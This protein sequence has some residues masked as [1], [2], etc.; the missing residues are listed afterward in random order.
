MVKIIKV[1]SLIFLFVFA[2]DLGSW[3]T[4]RGQSFVSLEVAHRIVDS[5]RAKQAAFAGFDKANWS[6]VQRSSFAAMCDVPQRP[7]DVAPLVT[8]N[9]FPVFSFLLSVALYLASIIYAGLKGGR[10]P[11]E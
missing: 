10:R 4:R 6:E 3:A 8:P 9:S 5:C 1:L 2:F 7:S 11:Q